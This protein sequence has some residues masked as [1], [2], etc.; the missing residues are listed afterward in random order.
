M[1]K[2]RGPDSTI[3]GGA[4]GAALGALASHVLDL[5]QVRP[6]LDAVHVL[7]DPLMDAIDAVRGVK[8]TAQ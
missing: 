8:K 3:A 4:I 5:P 7:R 2:Q 1:G 6:L